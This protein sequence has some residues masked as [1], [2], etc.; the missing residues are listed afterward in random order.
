MGNGIVGDVQS[1]IPGTVTKE[2]ILAK[3][4]MCPFFAASMGGRKAWISGMCEKAFTAKMRCR[5]E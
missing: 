2:A 3:V 4:T 5:D 1:A